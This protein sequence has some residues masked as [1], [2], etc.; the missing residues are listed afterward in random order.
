MKWEIR[1][2]WDGS[3]EWQVYELGE[4]GTLTV[5]EWEGKWMVAWEP[6]DR[7]WIAENID[8]ES[9]AKTLVRDRIGL[10]IA[11]LGNALAAGEPQVDE[12]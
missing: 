12:E 2:A 8:S 7:P 3:C 4:L 1:K 11:Q 9:A 6:S 10:A 5:E